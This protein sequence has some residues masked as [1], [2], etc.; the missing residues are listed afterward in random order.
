M[1]NFAD[2]FI[3]LT[4]MVGVGL[5]IF[6][7]ISHSIHS[8]AGVVIGLIAAA[9]ALMCMW[10]NLTDGSWVPHSSGV[11]LLFFLPAL[12]LVAY[13]VFHLFH[14]GWIG[15]TVTVVTAVVIMIMAM[16]QLG[17]VGIQ[18]PPTA[19]HSAA[20][21][22][23]AIRQRHPGSGSVTVSPPPST[24]PTVTVPSTTSTVVVAS[25]PTASPSSVRIS[26]YR[27]ATPTASY[28]EAQCA[29]IV[30]A[31]DSLRRS[32]GCL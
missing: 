13:H 17:R 11:S 1:A 20:T 10:T 21:Q 5:F 19:M 27:S 8:A 6:N 15:R 25:P 24:A 14:H 23:A 22:A 2:W 12:G 28:T 3:A 4:L 30:N 16:V 31:S 32:K 26:Q 7:A 29:K 9:F 18:P